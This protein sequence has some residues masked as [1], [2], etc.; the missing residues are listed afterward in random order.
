MRNRNVSINGL[1]L[2]ALLIYLTFVALSSRRISLAIA[3]KAFL[4]G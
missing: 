1:T 3:F 2:S 4:S